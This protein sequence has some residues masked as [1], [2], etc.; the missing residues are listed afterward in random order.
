MFLKMDIKDSTNIIC[1]LSV[2]K[3]NKKL[4]KEHKGEIDYYIEVI[5]DEISGKRNP[6]FKLSIKGIVVWLAEI[7]FKH[8]NSS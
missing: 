2:L 7:A 6:K 8:F 4:Y 3:E 1:F 5:K